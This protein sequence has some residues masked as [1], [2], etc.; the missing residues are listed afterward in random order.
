L[1]KAYFSDVAENS[2]TGNACTEDLKNKDNKSYFD[3][4]KSVVFNVTKWQNRICT[5]L[6]VFLA[7]L[8]LLKTYKKPNPITFISFFILY[9]IVLSGISCGQGDRF[10]LVTFPFMFLLLTKYLSE[11][12]WFKPFSEP[13]QK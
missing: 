5:L 6:G 11:T 8:F 4:W 2:K 12:K 1:V 3:F 9:I 13:L 7:T 10:H